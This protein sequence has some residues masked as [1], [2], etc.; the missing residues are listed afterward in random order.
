MD[1]YA[2]QWTLA[3][4]ECYERGCNCQGCY[5]RDLI[6]SDICRMK[7]AVLELVRKYGKPPA[8]L[9]G[10]FTKSEQEIVDAI[11]DGCNTFEE[12]AEHLNRSKETIQSLTH[13]LYIKARSNGWKPIKKGIIKHSLLPQFIKYLRKGGFESEEQ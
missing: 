5:M 6:T 9:G 2:R 10:L 7:G 11:L 13:G 1:N 4:K 12:I 3:A 8:R